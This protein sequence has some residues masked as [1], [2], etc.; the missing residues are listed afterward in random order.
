LIGVYEVVLP[1]WPLIRQLLKPTACL[2]AAYHG[3]QLLLRIPKW[4]M[5][6]S[7]GKTRTKFI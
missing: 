4:N 1:Q 6:W 3:Q 2:F 5:V 7:K